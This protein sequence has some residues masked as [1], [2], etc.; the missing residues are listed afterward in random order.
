M[1]ASLRLSSMSFI[2]SIRLL[3]LPGLSM[4]IN[5]RS[6]K[7]EKVFCSKGTFRVV[8]KCH[9]C[10]FHL[11]IPFHRGCCDSND[12]SES[13]P[14]QSIFLHATT[15]DEGRKGSGIP[16]MPFLFKKVFFRGF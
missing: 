2:T 15:P 3:H 10:L 16:G 8:A 9:S 6:F 7:K 1:I 12:L 14:D 11:V 5:K 4:A 13:P